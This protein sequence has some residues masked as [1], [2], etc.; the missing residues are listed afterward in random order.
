[1]FTAE[2]KRLRFTPLRFSNLYSLLHV[3]ALPGPLPTLLCGN[4]GSGN[5][6]NKTLISGY[7]YCCEKWNP[8]SL[9]QESRVFFASMKLWEANLLICKLDKISDISEFLALSTSE[10]HLISSC[11]FKDFAP[12]GYLLSLLH[13]QFFPFHCIIPQPIQVM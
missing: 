6:C 1:M 13:C 2:C 10:L 4:W 9:T 5:W 11:L 7:C 12:I 3:Q 8:L